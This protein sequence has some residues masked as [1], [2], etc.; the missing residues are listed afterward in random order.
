[1][2]YNVP[3]QAV[4]NQ[5]LTITLDSN[6][7]VIT[8]L[9]TN[10]VTCVSL[11]INGIETLDNIRCVAGTPLI[12]A[13]YQEAGNFL[14]ISNNYD[15]PIYT[16]FNISQTLVYFTAAELAAYRVPLVAANPRTPTVTAANFN[17]IAAL[18]LRFAPQGY[19]A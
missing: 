6:I 1:M 8:L 18:P 2:P 11:T 9:T 17:P 3:I 13:L 5:T 19:V 14:F 4:P 16:Q 15:L 7:F 10:G 12:P